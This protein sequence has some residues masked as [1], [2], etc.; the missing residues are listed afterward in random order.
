LVEAALLLSLILPAAGLEI[1]FLEPAPYDKT[2]LVYPQ[3][4]DEVKLRVLQDGEPLE[5]A[6][7]EVVS[8]PGSKVET[9]AVV[10][11]TRPDGTIEWIPEVGG[12][13]TLTASL[14]RKGKEGSTVTITTSETVSVRFRKLR[15]EGIL[16]LLF[17]GSF[18]FGG[19]IYSFRK[20]MQ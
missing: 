12:L 16:V 2:G 13:A 19:A 1:Q 11:V 8:I 20:L 10:G 7:V 15:W 18:L 14:E 5:G 17:A 4:G 9:T 3:V 6:L